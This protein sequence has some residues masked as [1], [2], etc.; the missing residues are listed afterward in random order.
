MKLFLIQL[1]DALL[2]LLLIENANCQITIR[3]Q[4]KE[5]PLGQ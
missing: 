2:N 3:S 5:N 1:F 4:Q